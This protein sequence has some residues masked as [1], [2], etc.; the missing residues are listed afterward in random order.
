[1][2]IPKTPEQVEQMAAAGAILTRCLHM[3]ASKARPGVTTKEL[4]EAAERFIRSQ[5]AV[6]AFKGYRGLPGL[7]LR[8]AQLDG[9]PRHPGPYELQARRRAL[10]RRRRGQGRLGRRRGDDGADRHRRRGGRPSCST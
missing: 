5:D 8:L 7:D 6:P 1:M 3:L 9:R 4:D 10:D 2:I